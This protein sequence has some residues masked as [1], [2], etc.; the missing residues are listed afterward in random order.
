MLYCGLYFGAAL[1]SLNWSGQ[2][3]LQLLPTLSL[4]FILAVLIIFIVGLYDIGR[5]KNSWVFFQKIIISGIIWLAIA[6]FFF[7]AAAGTVSPKTTLL[8]VA[9]ISFSLLG[10]WRYIYNRFVSVKLLKTAVVFAG[11][12]PET[13]ELANLFLSEPQR[14]F[15]VAGFILGETDTLPEP[16]RTLP[17]AGSLAGLL[18]KT[19]GLAIS[20]IVLAP[21][22]ASSSALATELYGALF[23]QISILSLADF[24]EQIF[25]R[26]PPFTFSEDWFVTHLKEQTRKMNDRFRTIIDYGCAIIMGAVTLVTLPFI[27]FAIKCSSPGAIFFKQLRVGRMGQPFM[28]YKFRTMRVMGK[29]GS[30]EISGPQ[31]AS[32]N[33]SRITSVGKFLRR[34]RLDE[35][36]QCLNILKGEMSLIGPRPER[37]EFAKE[38]TARIPFYTLRNLVKPGLTGWAQLQH[39]YYGNIEENL[40]KLEY[41][42]YYVKNRSFILDVIILLKTVNVVVR[43]M[44][45]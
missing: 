37:P 15:I 28:I 13:T 3:F 38:L 32:V 12:T 31:F 34:T 8:L 9:L 7:Y 36:P 23:S 43:M 6:V 24:Y 19:P 5:A 39:S 30:A 11:S 33:D 1:R 21:S 2:T 25:K 27:A 18:K 4:L 22:A 20:L 40:Y 41:D 16:L 35:L 26:I 17:Q 45:R 44:G 10:L 14:G 29:N 42:L